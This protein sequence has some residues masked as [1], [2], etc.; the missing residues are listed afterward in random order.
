MQNLKNGGVIWLT[1]LAGSGKSYIAEE[2]CRKLKE[3]LNNIIYLDGDE[4]RDL[5]GHYGYE[6][7]GRIEVSLKRSNF[8]H[9]LSSQGMIVIVST[10]SMW[11]EIYTYNRKRLKNYFEIYIKCDFEELKRRD[12]KGLY[13]G[14]IQG[15]IKNVV[16][17]DIDFD[18]PCSDL[19]IDNSKLDNLEEKVSTILNSL[20]KHL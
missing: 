6:K 3:K 16:G 7:E 19:I 2:L 8:A 12:K 4:L 9:F 14:A 15:D 1:G 13:S 11:N 18:E 5:L 10:I 17:V 20:Q